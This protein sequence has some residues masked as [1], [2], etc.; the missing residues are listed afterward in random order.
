MDDP[1]EKLDF[2]KTYMVQIANVSHKRV[3]VYGLWEDHELFIPPHSYVILT[4]QA[5]TEKQMQKFRFKYAREKRLHKLN[6]IVRLDSIA[7]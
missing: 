4:D 2:L 3:Y 7:R 1:L 6:Q 5:F